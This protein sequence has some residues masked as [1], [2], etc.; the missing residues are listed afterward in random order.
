MASLEARARGEVRASDAERDSCV[1]ALRHHYEVGRLDATEFEERVELAHRAGTRS[2]L[3]GL[4]RDLPK[5]RRRRSGRRG[6]R[7]HATV[8]TGVNGGLAAIWAATGMGAYWPG[9]VLA[10]WAV[11]LGWHAG[12]VWIA[13]GGLRPT[14]GEPDGGGSRASRRRSRRSMARRV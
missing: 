12:A 2:E 10:P 11:A 8:F 9:G 6:L 14:R 13:R 5:P 4:L 3:K 1:R 7:V